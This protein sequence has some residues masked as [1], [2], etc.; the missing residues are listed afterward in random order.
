MISFKR[1]LSTTV[2]PMLDSSHQSGGKRVLVTGA[3]NSLARFIA[4]GLHDLGYEITC[5]AVSTETQHILKRSYPVI[6]HAFS[7][8]R[9]TEALTALAPDVI[10]HA[11]AE[12]QNTPSAHWPSATFNRTVD[13]TIAL[14]EAVR[15]HALGTR[16][17]LL[18]SSS[19]YGECATAACETTQPAP[20]SLQGRY[21][22]MSETIA[23]D[24]ANAHALNLSILRVF[25]AYGPGVRSNPV[26]DT[27][28][29][30]LGPQSQALEIPFAANSSRD[31]VHAGDI[32]QAV[33]CILKDGAPG[34]YNVAS[35]Q[36]LPLREL[37][38]QL[39]A[40][41]ELPLP[42]FAPSMPNN[43]ALHERA[44]ISKLTSLGYVPQIPLIEGLRGFAAW[45]SGMKAA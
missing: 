44:D 9:F 25:S 43:E 3:E 11:S 8:L 17:M 41:L 30:L 14:C 22:L 40:I 6:E 42:K 19:V 31:F 27:L 20:T 18:S 36:S 16:L 10:I 12:P 45:W 24:F 21:Q 38:T 2:N 32:L 13:K 15:H 28:F 7:D 34:V 35:G 23:Q 5:Q 4:G 37:T 33:N 26:Y 1:N 39:C 29:K